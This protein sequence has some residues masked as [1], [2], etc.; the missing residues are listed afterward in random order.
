MVAEV[1]TVTVQHLRPPNI[2]TNCTVKY[3]VSQQ[4]PVINLQNIHECR[5]EWNQG[6]HKNPAQWIHQSLLFW[7]NDAL[8]IPGLT[9]ARPLLNKIN[10][11]LYENTEKMKL[12][13]WGNNLNGFCWCRTGG[14]R[15]TLSNDKKCAQIVG[16]HARN[17]F[18]SP[19]FFLGVYRGEIWAAN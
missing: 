9:E 15:G 2:L 5:A 8:I 4:T 19:I 3:V 18:A 10:Y 12:P 16:N 13:R 6:G 11:K 17:F 14:C 7:K 1:I